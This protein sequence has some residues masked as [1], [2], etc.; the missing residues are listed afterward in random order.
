MFYSLSWAEETK[1]LNLDWFVAGLTAGT[2]CSAM[3]WWFLLRTHD[4]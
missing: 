1:M 4:R 2:I 3:M